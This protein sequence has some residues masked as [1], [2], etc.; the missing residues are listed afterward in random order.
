VTERHTLYQ[1]PFPSGDYSY[2]Q[3]AFIVD[4]V[5]TAANRWADVHGVGPFFVLP[6]RGPMVVRY[7][8]TEA[9][10]HTRIAVSQAGPL[11]IELI[12]QLSDAPSVYRDIYGLGESGAHHLCT[13]T[14][15]YDRTAAHYADKGYALIAEMDAPGLGR[16]GYID[17]FKD[18]GLITEI[19]EWSDDFLTVLSKTARACSKW[20]G[21]D[22]VRFTR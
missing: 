6:D 22:P 12:E 18:F 5:V 11:Q 1:Q 9:E 15:D 2:M 3:L 7:H 13:M 16:V 4:D 19:V 8:G 17:T 21:T 14:R 20:D 10:L